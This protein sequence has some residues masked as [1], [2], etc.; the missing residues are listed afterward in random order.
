MTR[1]FLL[2]AVL[3]LLTTRLPAHELLTELRFGS[4]MTKILSRP[5]RHTTTARLMLPNHCG[6]ASDPDVAYEDSSSEE[7]LPPGSSDA[8][9]YFAEGFHPVCN[10]GCH[11]P[12]LDCWCD[13]FPPCCTTHCWVEY[14]CQCSHGNCYR[15]EEG[16][17]V[18]N[19]AFCDV[20]GT[21]L[22]RSNSALRFGW[23]AVDLKGSPTKVGEYQD[24][25]P[26]PFWDVDA[27]SSDGVRTWDITLTGLDNESSDAR[28]RYYGPNLSAKFDFERYPHRLDHNPLTGFN[29]LGPIPPR[30]GRSTSSAKTSTW[31]RITRSAFSSSTPNSKGN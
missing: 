23:W 26:S 16:T 18:S 12:P 21:S 22:Y 7:T 25:N 11:V 5:V 24:L 6:S 17:W 10:C 29:L 19:D 1:L 14:P 9:E 30:T 27:I 28:V 2:V 8:A 13:C 3:A 15:T 4:R 31:V 20:S